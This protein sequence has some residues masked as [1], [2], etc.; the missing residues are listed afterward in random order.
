[1]SQSEDRRIAEIGE[2]I[3]EISGKVIMVDG[4]EHEFMITSAGRVS[5]GASASILGSTVEALDS[6]AEMVRQNDYVATDEELVEWRNRGDEPGFK[7]HTDR[8]QEADQ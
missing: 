4:T 1:M 6:I 3:Q 2:K 5:W 8:M 7:D